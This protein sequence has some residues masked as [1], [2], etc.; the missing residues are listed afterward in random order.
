MGG[1]DVGLGGA[2]VAP[3]GPAASRSSV[4]RDRSADWVR[5]AGWSSRC[6]VNDEASKSTSQTIT[7]S[8][9]RTRAPGTAGSSA[10]SDAG[11]G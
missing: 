6:I 4:Q 5:L 9:S 7:L 10:G 3:D 1:R 11:I 8:Q 2:A